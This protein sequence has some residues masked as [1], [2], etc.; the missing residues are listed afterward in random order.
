MAALCCWFGQ[1]KRLAPGSW[2]EVTNMAHG[3]GVVSGHRRVL[4]ASLVVVTLFTIPVV[5]LRDQARSLASLQRVDEYP[6]YVL[7]LYGDYGLEGLLR[8][9]I[10]PPGGTPQPEAGTALPWACSA[11][12]AQTVDGDRILGRNFDWH[13]R[14]SLLLFT[15]PTHGYD[16]VSM[17]DLSYLLADADAASWTDGR[18]LFEA[19][20]WPFDGLNEAG[21]AVGMMAVPH[22]EA[23]NDPGQP[24]IGSLHAMR[25][26]LDRAATVEE[27]IALLADYNIDFLGGPP[28]HY[29]LADAAGDSALIE[30]VD[31][32]M[33]VLR[34]TVPWQVA[35]NF[36][37]SGR[38]P[39]A[40]TGLCRRYRTAY[41]TLGEAKSAFSEE[42]AM[43]LLER[44][45]QRIT[46]WSVVYNLTTGDI[47]V[48]V[49]RDYHS[50]HTFNLPMRRQER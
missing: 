36:V 13:N 47:H 38:N 31:G 22:A 16:A 1:G 45:S 5:L 30:F 12:A 37:M 48:S 20:L 25:L 23:P 7:H 42:Q 14:A 19:P 43:T 2:Q 33:S 10:Q 49:G 41:D 28:L 35:T 29:L 46:M 26:V 6:L 4:L 17:V 24:T 3:I 18:E 15:H 39:D 32:E 40:A 21:L 11:F 50:I 8:W 34:T 44:I 9:G 27:A